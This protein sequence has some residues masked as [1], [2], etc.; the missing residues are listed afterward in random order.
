MVA[1]SLGLGCL[2]QPLRTTGDGL[3]Y[4]YQFIGTSAVAKGSE[5]TNLKKVLAL[6][7]TR[8]LLDYALPLLAK[9]PREFWRAKL[10]PTAPDTSALVRPLL[11]DLVAAESYLEVRG[12]NQRLE[13]VLAIQLSDDRARLWQTNLW[14][15]LRAWQVGAPAS[16][17]IGGV[18]GWELKKHDPPN[19]IQCAR[20]GQWLLLGTGTDKLTLLPARLAQAQKSGRPVPALPADKLLDWEADLPRLSTWFP[21]LA[22]NPL[23][24]THLAVF[25]RGENLR[26][27][28]KFRYRAA[29]PFKPEPWRLATNLI[30]DPIISFTVGQGIGPLLSHIHGMP[31][32]GKQMPNQF[33]AWALSGTP[34]QT[35][36]TM[37]VANA[38]NTIQKLAPA[39][40]K[41]ALDK[42]GATKSGEIFWAS[43]HAEILWRG[44]PFIMP[45]LRPLHTNAGDFLYLSLFA[46]PAKPN[47][48]PAEMFAQLGGRNNLVYY[49]W[50]ITQERLHQFRQ[51]GTLLS[52][53]KGWQEPPPTAPTRAWLDKVEPL[54]TNTITEVTLSAP[55]E[56]TLVRK[57]HLGLTGFELLYLS[58]WLESPAFPWRIERPPLMLPRGAT[59]RPAATQTNR[60]ARAPGRQGIPLTPGPK[61]NSTNRPAGNPR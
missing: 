42:M 11:D 47:P 35:F 38:S 18:A 41:I 16:A 39:L 20:S 60:P 14:Q 25:G 40:P 32:L 26:T 22:N 48:P 61:P 8:G 33:C 3:L 51:L 31:D 59:N 7:E 23:P 46:R 43:N 34:W 4:R 49:D 24:P 55:N 9:A 50:E 56:L 13:A 44:L 36:L 45:S 54:L 17:P 58:R 15:W 5:A 12:P 37:P 6:P 1:L 53:V 27:E 21:V 29:L 2:E 52:I 19:L 10:S 30:Q 28:A 57:S